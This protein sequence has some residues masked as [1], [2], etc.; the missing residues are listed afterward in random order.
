MYSKK[1]NVMRVLG[2]DTG[3]NDGNKSK[4]TFS[5]SRIHEACSSAARLTCAEDSNSIFR[6]STSRIF[7][8]K[9]R[10]KNKNTDVYNALNR[11]ASLKNRVRE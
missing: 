4:Q 1:N 6:T 11:Q 8:Y 3:E 7:I 2:K 10:L 9:N 5:N